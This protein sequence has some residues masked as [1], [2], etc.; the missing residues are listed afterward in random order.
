VSGVA[1]LDLE[2]VARLEAHSVTAWPPSVCER[3]ADGWTFRATPGLARGRSNHALPPC[4]GLSPQEIADGVRRTEAFATSHGIGP[5]VQVSPLE[6]HGR[7]EERLRALGWV[8]QEPVLVMSATAAAIASAGPALALTTSGHAD[9]AWLRAWGS[10]EPA[11]DVQAHVDTVFSQLG[12]RARFARSGQQAV[13]IVVESG[14]LAGLFCLA[15]APALRRRGLGSALV[16]GLLAGCADQA[17]AYLQVEGHN[18]AAV[19]MY[20]RL[21]FDLTYRYRHASPPGTAF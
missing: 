21:G 9:Q 14:G 18:R 8:H 13:G 3:A 16:R 19:A 2:L 15:V 20:E 1:A 11:R 4:R 6:L 17:V 10:C 12:G 7:L 5:G